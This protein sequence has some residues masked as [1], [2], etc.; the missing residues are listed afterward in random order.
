MPTHIPAMAMPGP[1]PA[2]LAAT[3]RLATGLLLCLAL[4]GCAT[5]PPPA[6]A[7]RTWAGRPIGPPPAPNPGI[8]QALISRANQ[9]WDFFGRQTVVFK[10]SEESI[11]H[12]G[13]W[14]DD[15]G[16]YSGRINAYWR[17]AGKPR[18]DGRDCQEPWSAAFMSWVMAGGA[19]PESQFPPASAHW[20]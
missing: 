5:A 19:V 18:L 7:P 13:A 1:A 14:E 6:E 4:I 17:A 8:K 9:E 2:P 3:A 11:P 16:P 20:V 15:D 10:G 12:V